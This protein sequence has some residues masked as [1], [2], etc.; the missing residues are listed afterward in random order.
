M[1]T[2]SSFTLNDDT[3]LT[4]RLCHAW[5]ALTGFLKCLGMDLVVAT[6]VLV[7]T[8]Q[9]VGVRVEGVSSANH[10][11]ECNAGMTEM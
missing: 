6:H 8:C 3:P 1:W 11:M 5:D 9:T 10:L 4:H 2:L 7:A